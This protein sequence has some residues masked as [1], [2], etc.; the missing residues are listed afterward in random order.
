[1]NWKKLPL[2]VVFVV[3]L[4]APVVLSR[5]VVEEVARS[6]EAIALYGFYL[7]MI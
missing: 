1:M 3:L 2:Y 5:E 4:A 6:E 7:K